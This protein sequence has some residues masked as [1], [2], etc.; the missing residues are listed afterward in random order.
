MS[1]TP[2]RPVSSPRELNGQEGRGLR[3]RGRRLR[4]NA[5]GGRWLLWAGRGLLWLTLA[6]V[7]INGLQAMFVSPEPIA[8]KS[9]ASIAVD[10]GWAHEAAGAFAGAFARDYL[11][12]HPEQR[13][14][15]AEMLSRYLAEDLDSEVGWNG[16]GE[17]A[18]LATHVITVEV[19][20]RH[21]AVATVAAQVRRPPAQADEQRPKLEWV[22]VAVPLYQDS[23]GRLAVTDAPVFVAAPASADVPDVGRVEEDPTTA[24]QLR[25]PLT[26]FFQAYGEGATSDLD[27][28]LTPTA[29]VTGLD[30]LVTFDELDRLIVPVGDNR[31]DVIAGVKWRHGAATVLQTYQLTVVREGDRWYVADLSAHTPGSDDTQVPD[32]Q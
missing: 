20:D 7:A 2:T 18:V 29:V 17:Q 27:Y 32:P 25:E 14:Q 19:L 1:T 3:G 6:I 13:G 24:R 16:E 26:S 30:G 5:G 15:R 9:A 28:F 12:L 11:T 8:Q 21:Q 31:R 22:H 23:Q 10:D 4:R